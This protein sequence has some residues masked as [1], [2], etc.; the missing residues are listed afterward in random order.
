MRGSTFAAPALAFVFLCS[1]A[2]SS[3]AAPPV[4]EADTL[5]KAAKVL[6]DSGK[7]AEA[8]AAFEQSKRL[9]SGV[10][11]TLYLA[12]CYERLGRT[13]SAWNEFREAEKLA[14]DRGDKRADVAHTHASTL[15]SEVNRV[16]VVVSPAIPIAGAELRIDAAGPIPRSEW[17]TGVAV[18][19]GDHTVTLAVPGTATRTVKAHVDAPS[20][21]V[22]V[23][24]EDPPPPRV[25]PPPPAPAVTSAPQPES[26]VHVGPPTRDLVEYGLLGA[27]LVGVGFG[28]AF[29][30]AKNQSMSN[31]GPGGLPK[32]NQ[33]DA[34]ASTVGFVAGG[35]ALVS[36]IVLYLTAPADKESALVVAPS[37]IVGRGGAEG[38][39]AFVR[40]TF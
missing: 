29:L 9:A 18:D 8:C 31:D 38:A 30:A 6:R 4:A 32:M 37:P 20:R 28:A 26:T 7:V 34:I 2:R 39:G 16:V 19:P 17:Q 12:D 5:F 23:T 3:H 21:S 22:T 40:A 33:G 10:G 11:V 1:A 24:I 14:R 36:A 15:E 13:A 25:A 27:G 35:A